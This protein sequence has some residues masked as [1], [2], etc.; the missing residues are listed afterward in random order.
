[1]TFANKV[2][3]F[4]MKKLPQQNQHYDAI[5]DFFDYRWPIQHQLF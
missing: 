3:N 4:C 2:N 1:M 5:C